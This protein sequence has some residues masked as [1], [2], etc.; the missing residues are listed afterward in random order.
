MSKMPLKELILGKQIIEDISVF[1]EYSFLS[2]IVQFKQFTG[3]PNIIIHDGIIIFLIFL[4]MIYLSNIY[5]SGFLIITMLTFTTSYFTCTSFIV[6]GYFYVLYNKKFIN[7][8]KMKRLV[9]KI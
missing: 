4:I 5:F 1:N 8:L 9:I 3:I 2:F 6:L 7:E